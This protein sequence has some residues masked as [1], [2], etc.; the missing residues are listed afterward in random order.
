MGLFCRK[1]WFT[2]LISIF[3]NRDAA[4]ILIDYPIVTEIRIKL[5]VS[6]GCCLFDPDAIKTWINISPMDQTKFFQIR[7][8]LLWKRAYGCMTTRRLIIQWSL[9]ILI[10]D[11]IVSL[12]LLW[13][14]RP[15]T[16]WILHKWNTK[17]TRFQSKRVLVAELLT[18]SHEDRLPNRLD[19]NN[20]NRSNLTYLNTVLALLLTWIK[21][22]H[23]MDK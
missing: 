12:K 14:Q 5:I 15:Q 21:F 19:T 6:V 9:K 13:D 23:S 7:T 17:T 18:Y 22:N 3:Q 4:N 8:A 11:I 2:E 16:I 10:I 20:T 1:P